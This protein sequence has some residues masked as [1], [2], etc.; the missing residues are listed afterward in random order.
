MKIDLEKLNYDDECELYY[1]NVESPCLSENTI[2]YCYP[3]QA[4]EFSEEDY[5]CCIEGLSKKR[6]TS[7]IELRFLEPWSSEGNLSEKSRLTATFIS[8]NAS[9]I[10]MAT[11][12]KVSELLRVYREEYLAVVSESSKLRM[13]EALDFLSSE[14]VLL[15]TFILKSITVIPDDK[16]EECKYA[17]N[18]ISAWDNMGFALQFIGVK[19][20]MVGQLD[21]F[22]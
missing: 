3:N 17:L 9:H 18:F 7:K 13:N 21:N 16:I 2:S 19:V 14:E 20:N 10:Q 6:N 1:T 8:E 5:K 22:G 12:N 4:V 15:N 11:M